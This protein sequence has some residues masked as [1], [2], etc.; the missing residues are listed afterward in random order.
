MASPGMLCH[1]ALVRTDLSEEHITF[2]IIFGSVL[3]LLVTVNIPSSLILVTL[4]MKAIRSSVTSVLTRAKWCNIPED[5]IL[6]SHHHENLNSYIVSADFCR[7]TLIQG[8]V[9]VC[10]FVFISNQN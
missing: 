3:R 9:F 1:V 6:N 5:G 8:T 7:W 2:I 10:L 4:M